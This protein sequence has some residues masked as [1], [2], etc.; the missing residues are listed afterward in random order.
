METIILRDHE[1]LMAPH[2]ARRE[3]ALQLSG[4]N[5]AVCASGSIAS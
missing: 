2:A 5:I 3:V 4:H 1:P